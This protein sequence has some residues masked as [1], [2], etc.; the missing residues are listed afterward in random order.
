MVR[1]GSV[2]GEILIPLVNIS[3]ED[4]KQTEKTYQKGWESLGA[5]AILSHLEG[6][7]SPFIRLTKIR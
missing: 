3:L 7:S 6:V 1:K 5:F 2:T 4:I